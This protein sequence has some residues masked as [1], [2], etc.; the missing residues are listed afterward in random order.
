MK[1]FIL[2]GLLAVSSVWA[3][4]NAAKENEGEKVA[5]N[6]RSKRDLANVGGKAEGEKH[7]RKKRNVEASGDSSELDLDVDIN[8]GGSRGKSDIDISLNV[9]SE[10]ICRFT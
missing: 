1:C 5:L 4:P 10:T 3:L 2:L 9:D 7:M 8:I 6:E